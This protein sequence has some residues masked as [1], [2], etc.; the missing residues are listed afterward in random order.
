MCVF[1]RLLRFSLGVYL[2]AHS[3]FTMCKVAFSF[4]ADVYVYIFTSACYFDSSKT[5]FA[6]RQC[7]ISR[8]PG[9]HRK[10]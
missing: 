10:L 6:S 4:R 2:L 5:V 3:E 8:M 9:A 1:Y 7:N